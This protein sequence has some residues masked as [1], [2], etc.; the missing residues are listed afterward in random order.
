MPHQFPFQC[1]REFIPKIFAELDPPHRPKLKKDLNSQQPL[2][3]T[4][5]PDANRNHQKTINMSGIARPPSPS[6]TRSSRFPRLRRDSLPTYNGGKEAK[7]GS[8]TRIVA[9]FLALAGLIYWASAGSNMEKAG[10]LLS[11]LKNTTSVVRERISSSNLKNQ[12][13]EDAKEDFSG[14]TEVKGK[15]VEQFAMVMLATEPT[16]YGHPSLVNKFDYARKHGF[17]L[18]SLTTCLRLTL[19]VPLDATLSFI[20]TRFIT[21][22]V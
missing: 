9:V 15:D 1:K 7:K 3:P 10:T 6:K 19:K 18:S 17:V 2:D 4:Q 12:L 13:K 20:G 8:W 5:A 21:S 14:W 22:M 16:T 11:N